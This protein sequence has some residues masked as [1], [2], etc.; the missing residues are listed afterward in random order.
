MRLSHQMN[1]T[2]SA[3]PIPKAPRIARSLQPSVG[4]S[5]MP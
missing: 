1:P 2:M 5:M 3:T 4:A